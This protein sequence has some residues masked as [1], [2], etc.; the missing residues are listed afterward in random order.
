MYVKFV[1][2][3]LSFKLGNKY[4]KLENGL[5]IQWGETVSGDNNYATINF[6]V[7]FINT[8]YSLTASPQ[9]LNTSYIT[10]ETSCQK[11]IK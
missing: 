4:L 6:E 9:Y 11:N 3:N 7:P 8:D 5:V 1:Y 2:T 10:F